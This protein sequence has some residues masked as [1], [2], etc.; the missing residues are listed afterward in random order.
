MTFSKLFDRY[1]IQARLMPGLVVVF[2]I[3]AT[4]A[5]WLPAQNLGWR[6]LSGLISLLLLSLVAQ[7][8][9]DAGKRRE[10]DLFRRW[11]G[12]PSVRKV[13]HRHT[14]LSWITLARLHERLA[15]DV[16]L[17]APTPREEH[18]APDE[19]DEIYR[20][21]SDHLREAMRGDP[22]LFAENISYGFRRNLWGMRPAGAALA[23]LGAVAN[24]IPAV[25][26][27][28]TPAMFLPAVVTATCAGL[29]AVWICRVT[30]DWVRL[31]ADAYADRLVRGYLGQPKA[32]LPVKTQ[33]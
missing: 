20:S 22:L 10:L 6:L 19:A 26:S 27:F 1:T 7:I 25:Q 23:I 9:R 21:F 17:P 8:G 2:P 33:A 24:A 29:A 15:T 31:A 3:A 28:G 4:V 12:S 18:A 14:D 11:D 30:P 32:A 5:V 13:R 16:G